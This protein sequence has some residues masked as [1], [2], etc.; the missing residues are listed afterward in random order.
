MKAKAQLFKQF[1]AKQKKK[2][3]AILNMDDQ[4]VREMLPSEPVQCLFYSL[5]NKTDA[6]LVNYQEDITGLSLTVSL[7]GKTFSLQTPLVGLFNA[8]NI[9][10]SALYGYT[11]GM[12]TD[13][14]KRDGR[15]TECSWQVRKSKK[16]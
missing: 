10:A 3:Y 1:G 2:R 12:T 14:E 5:K 16:R 7:R 4:A 9:L 11:L 6:Y 8:S 13:N 15:V